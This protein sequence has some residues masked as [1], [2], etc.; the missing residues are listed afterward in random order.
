MGAHN[1]TIF[2]RFSHGGG[3]GE[4]KE[5]KREGEEEKGKEN[6]DRGGGVSYFTVL[7]VIFPL[8]MPYGRTKTRDRK[9]LS[10]QTPGEG[11]DTRR[12]KRDKF[13]PL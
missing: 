5:K 2:T 13:P 9:P 11:E 12:F 1:G 8:Q 10:S 4:R 7:P 6:R 3:E